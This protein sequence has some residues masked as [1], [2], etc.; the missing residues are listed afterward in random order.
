VAEPESKAPGTEST[1]SWPSSWPA[2]PTSVAEPE[3]EEPVDAL[4]TEPSPS[5]ATDTA[6]DLSDVAET[7]IEEAQEPIPMGMGEGAEEPEEPVAPIEPEPMDAAAATV[8]YEPPAAS[9]QPASPDVL[10]RAND[11]LDELRDLLPSLA[12]TSTSKADFGTVVDDLA[13]ARQAA[14]D[15]GTFE[16]LRSAVANAQQR[17]RDIDT[18]LDISGRLDAVAALQSA[19]DRLSAAVDLVLEQLGGSGDAES[20][21]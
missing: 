9:M 18:M 7:E 3:A 11:L 14:A 8:D 19:Y 17:P 2:Q 15:D 6:G 16:S 20:G 4:E 21:V 1:G 13:A 10:A 12:I 5:A